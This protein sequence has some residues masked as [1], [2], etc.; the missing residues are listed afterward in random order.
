MLVID[1][2]GRL[3]CER[4]SFIDRIYTI[5]NTS[6]HLTSRMRSAI[7]DVLE[8]V[9]MVVPKHFSVQVVFTYTLPLS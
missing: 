6:L 9:L 3:V 2:V 7:S 1:P 4:H 5:W 8:R